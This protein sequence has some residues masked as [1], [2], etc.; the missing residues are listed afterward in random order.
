VTGGVLAAGNDLV[1]AA[2][3]WLSLARLSALPVLQQCTSPGTTPTV[4][5]VELGLFFLVGLFGSGHCL[6]MCGPLVTVYSDRMEGAAGSDRVTW[7][8]V[9]QHM[10][11]NAGRVTVYTLLGAAFGALGLVTFTTANATVPVGDEVRATTGVVVGALIVAAGAGYL[12][13]GAGPLTG[14]VPLL[15]PAFRRVHGVLRARIDRWVNGPRIFA[16]GFVHGFLPCP[17]LYPAF[18]YA[19]GQADPVRGA[20]ALFVL[21]VGTYPALL[22]YGTAFQSVSTRGRRLVHR[23]LG[24][25]FVLLGVHTLFAGLRLFGVAV[26]NL[27]SLPFYQPLG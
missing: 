19:F 21:G 24:A 6:G 23:A 18:L 12:L 4:Q 15:G 14:S 13:G 17:L 16:L 1:G 27:F 8:Q 10:L 9:R 2:P 7:A 26:P 5:S 25:A 20:T 22:F 3:A 11:F